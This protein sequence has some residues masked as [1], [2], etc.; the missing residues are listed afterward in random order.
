M[1]C[2][3]EKVNQP[4][5]PVTVGNICQVWS[6][7]GQIPKFSCQIAT[8]SPKMPWQRKSCK[9]NSAVRGVQIRARKYGSPSHL[10]SQISVMVDVSLTTLSVLPSVNDKWD[11]RRKINKK[12]NKQRNHFQKLVTL[13][14]CTKA[15]FSSRSYIFHK[16]KYVRYFYQLR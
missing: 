7:F 8:N 11:Q 5:K 1:R 3:K 10:K 12:T 9:A 15:A 16:K 2:L 13:Y 6:S 14:F 4:A